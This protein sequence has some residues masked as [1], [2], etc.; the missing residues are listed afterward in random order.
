MQC[1]RCR[2]PV[3]DDRLECPSCGEAPGIP[4]HEPRERLVRREIVIVT[5]GV[6]AVL[7]AAVLAWHLTV[8]RKSPRAVVERFMEADRRGEFA[9]AELLVSRRADSRMLLGAFRSLRQSLGF[10]PFDSARVLAAS[11]SNS[12]ASVEVEVQLPQLPSFPGV[13]PGTPPPI[14]QPQRF[15][16]SLVYEEGEWRIDPA[17]TAAGIAGA[18]LAAGLQK[19]AGFPS[20]L[21]PGVAPPPSGA[22]PAPAV[23]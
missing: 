19:A 7:G 13:P 20:A 17:Q 18:L 2:K 1:A 15:T 16:F 8:A 22:S 4:R 23:P 5:A 21:I 9:S 11:S 6:L 3:P 10:S 12:M 14:R